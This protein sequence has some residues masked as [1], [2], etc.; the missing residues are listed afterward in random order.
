TVVPLPALA[1]RDDLVDA[2]RGEGR[3]EAGDVPAVLGDRMAD[4]ESLDRAQLFGL[5][6]AAESMLDRLHPGIVGRVSSARRAQGANGGSSRTF[7]SR[8]VSG[9]LSP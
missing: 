2:V 8:A 1:G 3:D 5:E 4:P 9:R 6:R 7:I